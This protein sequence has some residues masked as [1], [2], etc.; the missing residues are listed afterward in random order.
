MSDENLQTEPADVE[1]AAE[2]G[3]STQ[4]AAPKMD[5]P[6]LTAERDVTFSDGL[7]LAVVAGRD[8][9]FSDGASGV[10]V[11]GG[12]LQLTDGAGGLMVIGGNAD[13]T[14][15]LVVSALAG[16]ANLQNSYCGVLFSGNTTLGEGSRVLINTPQ[17]LALGAAFGLVF[18]LLSWLLRKK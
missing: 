6:V 4:G 11:V 7:A 17:A 18:G 12:N 16:Q 1:S 14:D 8:V 5:D 15:G 10:T 2:E 3:D 13:V 9:E